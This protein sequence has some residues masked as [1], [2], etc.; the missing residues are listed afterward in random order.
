MMP[1]EKKRRM[2]FSV[3]S[4][5]RE[6]GMPLG[7]MSNEVD[8]EEEELTEAEDMTEMSEESAPK[9]KKKKYLPELD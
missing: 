5:L 3:I 1:E 6:N 8:K 2:K 4:M 7:P 9:K